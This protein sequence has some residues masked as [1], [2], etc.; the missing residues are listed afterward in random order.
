MAG[1]L[2][3]WAV[4]EYLIEVLGLTVAEQSSLVALIYIIFFAL[5]SLLATRHVFCVHEIGKF[6]LCST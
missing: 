2:K 4:S 1:I 3:N 6:C 5:Q